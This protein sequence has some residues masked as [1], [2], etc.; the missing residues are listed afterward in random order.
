MVQLILE[1]GFPMWFLLLFGAGGLVCAGMFA[2]KPNRERLPLLLALTA[3]IVFEAIMGVFADL[4]AVGHHVSDNFDKFQPTL[5]QSLLQ[6]FAEAMA[7]GVLGFGL[8]ATMLLLTV[9]G[10]YREARGA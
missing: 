7:P 9:L 8:V 1:G 6:G 5:V 10:F 2:Y 4:A 3:L